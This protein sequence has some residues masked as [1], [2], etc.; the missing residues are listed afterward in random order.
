MALRARE[1]VRVGAIS[2]GDVREHFIEA[3]PGKRFHLDPSAFDR[4]PEASAGREAEPVGLPYT[5]GRER[6]MLAAF[7]RRLFDQLHRRAADVRAQRPLV[8]A[9]GATD[10]VEEA[11]EAD[12][13]QGH[14]CR[15]VAP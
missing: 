5:L 13:L 3:G 7:G 10:P 15:N 9:D 1:Q 2:I 8:F 11:I 4:V 12:R 6:E 14:A